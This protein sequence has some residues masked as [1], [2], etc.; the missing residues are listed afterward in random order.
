[1]RK[2]AAT[3]AQQQR[4]RRQSLSQE[5]HQH[6]LVL[7]NDIRRISLSQI[8]A[9]TS[10]SSSSAV[11]S[12][13]SSSTA[14]QNVDNLLYK[15]TDDMKEMIMDIWHAHLVDPNRNNNLDDSLMRE[16]DRLQQAHEREETIDD[17]IIRSQDGR[18]D[19]PD[20]NSIYH[21]LMQSRIE[22]DVLDMVWDDTHDHHGSIDEIIEHQM[23]PDVIDPI[24]KSINDSVQPSVRRVVKLEDL[25]QQQQEAV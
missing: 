10:S 21:G 5:Q 7:H 1:M 4:K 8:Q 22:E 6:S 9:G 17:N 18:F 12:S 15:V 2:Q 19:Q 14:I 16:I 20:F 24:W 23:N 25:K 13:S 11:G 3:K